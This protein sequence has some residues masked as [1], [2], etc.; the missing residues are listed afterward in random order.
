MTLM[1]LVRWMGVVL[2]GWTLVAIGIGASGGR[3]ARRG[4]PVLLDLASRSMEAMPTGWPN[5]RSY[6]L[7]DRTDGR[8]TAIRLPGEDRWSLVSV[9]PWR[10]PGG[11]LEAVGRWINPDREE[12]GGWAIFRPSDGVVLSRVPTEL[13]PTA[14]PCWVPGRER[15]ILFA[16]GDGRLYTCRLDPEDGGASAGGGSVYASG[17]AETSEPLI[18]EA[19]PPGPGDPMLG[20]PAWST[21]SRLSRWIFA[22]LMPIVTR[23]HRLAY[24]PS[25]LWWLEVAADARSIVAAGRLAHPTP[26]ERG[27]EER[28]P[29]VAV[30]PEGDIRLVYL[31]RRILER[32]YH[33]R[34]A[35][36]EFDSRTGRPRALTDVHSPV[37]GPLG[38]LL[39]VPL[40]VSADGG[41]VY[42][43]SPSE[44]PVGLP[45]VRRE[46]RA[47][48]DG[49][50]GTGLALP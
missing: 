37:P 21:D 27:V 34:S 17:R 38:E 1:S 41:T 36:L 26:G 29:T 20:E 10:G 45:V 22:T 44:R 30:G 23:D 4:A 15:T 40:V 42:G 47:R 6:D 12:F 2:I 8:R 16:A 25:Q 39:P 7:V 32:T 35:A 18:W 3:T 11:E 5:N 14:R 43:L 33:L 28:F 24:G 31:E 50:A 46:Q 48:P 9:S 19:A 49:S 13:L